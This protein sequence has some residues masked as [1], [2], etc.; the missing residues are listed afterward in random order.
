M[1]AKRSIRKREHSLKDNS[2]NYSVLGNEKQSLSSP[3]EI[4]WGP[5]IYCS[6]QNKRKLKAKIKTL[7]EKR[8]VYKAIKI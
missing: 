8:I 4:C 7:Q 5:T 1:K 3:K 6:I 2:E